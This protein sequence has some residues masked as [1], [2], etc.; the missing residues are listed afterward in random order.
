MNERK[1]IIAKIKELL[2]ETPYFVCSQCY[3]RGSY[4]GGTNNNLSDVDLLVVSQDFC[5]ITFRKRKELL[6]KALMG[7]GNKLEIDVICLSEE[8]YFKL[9]DDKREMY[10]ME[11]MIKIL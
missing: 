4:V 8:E 6:R 3:L 1:K 10:Y 9:L 11:R 2:L 5:W 7:L